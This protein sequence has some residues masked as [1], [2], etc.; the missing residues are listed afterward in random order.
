MIHTHLFLTLFESFLST[1]DHTSIF[2]LSATHTSW[3]PSIILDSSRTCLF[4]GL[5]GKPYTQALTEDTNQ[6]FLSSMSY[7]FWVISWHEISKGLPCFLLKW[8]KAPF[9]QKWSQG[10]GDN[11]M[12]MYKAT[13]IWGSKVPGSIPS[14]TISQRFIVHSSLCV[15]LYLIK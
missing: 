13:H 4:G 14:I 5:I 10:Y 2:S 6:N 9:F 3:L 1:P 11:I 8:G 12:V 15:I 7:D